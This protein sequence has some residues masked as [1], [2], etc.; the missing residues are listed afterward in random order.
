MGLD[1][2]G[3][4]P[5]YDIADINRDLERVRDRYCQLMDHQDHSAGCWG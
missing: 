4:E 5:K 2:S 3:G 1:F